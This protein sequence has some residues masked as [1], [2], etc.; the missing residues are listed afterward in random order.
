MNEWTLGVI[1]APEPCDS[2]V[3]KPAATEFTWFTTAAHVGKFTVE[4]VAPIVD[5]RNA[6]PLCPAVT[7]A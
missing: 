4:G 6:G 3:C 1:K 7:R 2:C 5:T